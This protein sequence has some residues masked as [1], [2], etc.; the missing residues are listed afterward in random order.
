MGRMRGSEGEKIKTTV[1]ELQNIIQKNSKKRY[2]IIF[3]AAL[4]IMDK[5]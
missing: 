3:L 1:L 5:N 2:K 4:A